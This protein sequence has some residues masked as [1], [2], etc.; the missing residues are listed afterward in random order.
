MAAAFAGV[1]AGLFDSVANWYS[2]CGNLLLP[3]ADVILTNILEH[4]STT[5]VVDAWSLA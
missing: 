4:A 3:I 1:F 2:Q 5:D